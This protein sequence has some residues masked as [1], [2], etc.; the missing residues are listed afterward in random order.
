MTK[1]KSSELKMEMRLSAIELLNQS[2]HLPVA[3]DSPATNFTFNINIESKADAVNKLVFV[4][5]NVDIRNDD[6]SLIL[7]S[8]SVSCIYEIVNFEELIKTDTEGKYTIPQP[9]IEILNSI[10][11]STIRGVMFS[12]FRGTF[13]HN[14][15]LPIVDP[16]QIQVAPTTVGTK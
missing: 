1:I 12:T 15:I 14:A 7:G 13:L 11:I 3:S 10:S 2:L 9:M 16:K 5:V 4:I 6:Q 8:L